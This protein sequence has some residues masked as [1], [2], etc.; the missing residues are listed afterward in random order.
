MNLNQNNVKYAIFVDAS[1]TILGGSNTSALGVELFPDSIKLLSA[2][3]ERNIDGISIKTGLITNWGNRI[4]AMLKA[5]NVIDCF[6]VVISAD[7]TPKGKP[8]PETFHY[9]C[10]LLGVELRNAIHIGDSLFDDALGAQNAGLHG[11][12]LRRSPY[13]NKD[14]SMLKHPIFD[15]LNDVLFYL[16]TIISK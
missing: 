11:I 14:S 16:D 3:R 1:G 10:S 2:L 4:N 12:W 9:A 15:N 5:L 13:L 6:D 7:D 8:D